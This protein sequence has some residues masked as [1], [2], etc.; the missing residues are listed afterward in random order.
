MLCFSQVQYLSR[1][2]E[3]IFVCFIEAG[4]STDQARLVGELKNICHSVHTVRA[5]GGAIAA[6]TCKLNLYLRGVPAR[7][8]LHSSGSMRRALAEVIA[9]EAPDAALVQF[10]WMAQYVDLL[11]GVP[12]VMDV[13]DSF[14]VSAYRS[15]LVERRRI[16][17]LHSMVTWLAWVR[18]ERLFYPR[19]S[20]VV[21]LT[22]Q[23]RFGLTLFSP[24]LRPHVSPP[25][26]DV[27][28]AI[29]Q[30][31]RKPG[32]LA[33][34]GAL[35]HPPN[36][37]GLEYFLEEVFPL[38][39][40]KHPSVELLVAGKSAPRRLRRYAS[41]NIRFVGFVDDVG[42]FLGEAS[43]V[44]VPLISGGGIKVKTLE[45]LGWRTPVVSTSIGAEETGAIDGLHLLIRDDARAF[46]DAVVHLMR[47]PMEAERL[48]A[49][50]N[51]LVRTRFCCEQR[52]ADF[53]RI[54]SDAALRREESGSE[55]D[56]SWTRP[57]TE[58]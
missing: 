36:V 5:P 14:S 16:R 4:D 9:R 32:R 56:G 58:L 52:R 19:F 49:A 57:A 11:G 10:P 50:G 43:V 41:H 20:E 42:S 44:V 1:R 3:V 39:V 38:V 23:D 13:Q 25:A 28:A 45:A 15:A 31:V 54:L 48:A 55:R 47:N 8:T 12:T 7:V 21:V 2:H 40:E 17:K 30:R 24:R 51:E 29:P 18:H 22:D 26:I 34:V 53:A 6:M 35:S 46:A 27:P 33:F 37:A